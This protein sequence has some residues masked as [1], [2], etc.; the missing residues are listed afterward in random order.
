MKN[1]IGK[2]TSITFDS[3]NEIESK[4][5]RKFLHV[6]TEMGSTIGAILI[7][8]ILAFISGRDVLYVFIPIYLFQL[9]MVE[10]LKIVFRKPR[11]ES[12]KQKNL[13][14]KRITSGSFPS[15]HTSNIFALAFL[16]TNYYQL[17]FIWIIAVFIV[18]GVIAFSRILLGRHFTIDVAAGAICGLFF[19]IVGA[20]L[21]PELL[22]FIL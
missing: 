16:I 13:F 19:S 3:E 8:G 20:M 4:G 18:A 21:L 12:H 11:P 17:S 2:V 7:I 9:I 22:K 5:L 1:F 15:G 10:V 14:G 6:F